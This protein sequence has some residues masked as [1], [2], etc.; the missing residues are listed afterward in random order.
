MSARRT[1][2]TD[3]RRRDLARIHLGAARLG[4]DDATYRDMLWSVSRVRSA[5]DLGHEE[6]QRVIA[7]LQARGAY[8]DDRRP[9]RP[10]PPR[11]RAALVG[12][13]RALLL[14]A[15]LTDAYG[16]GIARRM[17]GADRYE[18]CDPDQLRR[19]VAA[20]IYA[21]RRRAATP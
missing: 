6:R 4:L 11:D 10:R 17:F 7:H 3:Q 20:L 14:S 18:W 12:K 16:D 9:R 1:V 15:G 19:I 21:A 8:P 5:R 2:D 13:V